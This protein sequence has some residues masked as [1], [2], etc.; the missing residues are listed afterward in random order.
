VGTIG[1][2]LAIL[3]LPIHRHYRLLLFLLLLLLFLLL[4]LLL[5]FLL[6]LLLLLLFPLLFLLLP[7]L[8]P[9]HFLLPQHSSAQ[10]KA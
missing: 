7:M 5:L 2:L 4:L 10:R 6:F 9:A 1:S 8:S 3:L